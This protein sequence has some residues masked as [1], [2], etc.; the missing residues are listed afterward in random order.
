MDLKRIKAEAKLTK[1]A[2][3]YK[4]SKKMALSKDEIRYAKAWKHHVSTKGHFLPKTITSQTLGNLT[5]H[6]T[7]F[8]MSINGVDIGK[9]AAHVSANEL[10]LE[11]SHFIDED[12]ITRVEDKMRGFEDFSA[13]KETSL[14]NQEIEEQ[15]WRRSG[16]MTEEDMGH[17][18]EMY[19][20][21]RNKSY[22]DRLWW[23]L[24]MKSLDG[25]MEKAND[26]DSR[27]TLLKLW[28]KRKENEHAMR[29]TPPYE[30]FA[31]ADDEYFGWTQ[32]L[33]REQGKPVVER[34]TE[35]E[36]DKIQA[37]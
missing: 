21:M 33:Y 25:F 34:M 32:E 8:I 13:N 10:I 11:L 1:A 12:V 20:T 24:D 18:K 22:Q 37:S 19:M 17:F 15:L 27:L 4:L 2:I 30:N 26:Y 3:I 29:K 28:Y 6:D 31:K 36:W 7:G 9:E 5:P 35:T 23:G 14:I 16:Q